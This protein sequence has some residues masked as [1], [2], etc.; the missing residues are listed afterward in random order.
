MKVG[1]L[2]AGISFCGVGFTL[3]LLALGVP[4]RALA[5]AATWSPVLL[6]LTGIWILMKSATPRS[7]V[8]AASALL[9]MG[10]LGLLASRDLASPVF[11]KV[12]L[13]AIIALFGGFLARSGVRAPRREPSQFRAGSPVKRIRIGPSPAPEPIPDGAMAVAVT[14]CFATVKLTLPIDV[15]DVETT[16]LVGHITLWAPKL[17]PA[18]VVVHRAFV[19]SRN[20]L[21]THAP[22]AKAEMDPRKLT[23]VVVSLGGAVDVRAGPNRQAV[24]VGGV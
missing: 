24:P 22:L 2:V 1:R 8:I 12:L 5:E 4:A 18:D 6:L 21:T 19:L 9:L 15:T 20:G 13:S 11:W 3:G 10:S 23:I 14:A 7:I 17:S 16:T